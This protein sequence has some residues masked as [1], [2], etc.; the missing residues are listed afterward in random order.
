MTP[1]I[2]DI[3]RHV[4]GRLRAARLAI[5]IS[6]EDAGHHVG[7]SF[8]QIQKYENGSNRVSAGRLATL[9]VIY[10]RPLL[11]FF[12]DCPGFSDTAETGPDVAVQ[13]L[14]APHGRRLA[15]AFLAIEHGADCAAL[16]AVAEALAHRTL[17]QQAAE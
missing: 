13:M 2:T 17:V 7:V 6:Q 16:A 14:A 5:G 15:L 8:Q 11:W 10:R 9:S 4:A 3:D 1:R 12:G